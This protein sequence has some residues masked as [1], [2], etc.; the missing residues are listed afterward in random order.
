[1][2]FGDPFNGAPVKGISR[3]KIQDYCAASDP[4][5]D[6]QLKITA[7]HMSYVGGDTGKAAKWMM[8]KVKKG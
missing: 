8:E 3:D 6:G 1:V 4:V 2:L 5:C 7:G